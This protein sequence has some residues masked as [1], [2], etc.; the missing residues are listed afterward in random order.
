M[1]RRLPW[2]MVPVGLRPSAG[3]AAHLERQD[4]PSRP[5]GRCVFRP[6]STQ[7]HAPLATGRRRAASSADRMERHRR[8]LSGPDVP[9]PARGAQV[10]RTPTAVA[11]VCGAEEISYE[12]LNV[13]ANQLAR[14]LRT[15]G[16]GPDVVVGLCL[17][18]SIELVVGLLAILKAGGAYMPLD[19]SY[20]QE[21]LRLMVEDA[22]A[23]LLVTDAR[24]A[25]RLGATGADVV[26]LETDREVLAADRSD[27]L[28]NVATTDNLASVIF[29]SGSTG[30]PKGAMIPHRAICNHM[31]WMQTAFPLT[32]DDRV[33]QRTPYSFDAS[34]WEFYAPLIAGARLVMAPPTV[35]FDASGLVDIIAAHSVSIPATRP[36][37]AGAAARG[38]GS[39]AVREPAACL[40]WRRAALL[41]AAGAV[42]RAVR[43][44][45]PQLVR[46]GRSVHRR[47]VLDVLAR[48]RPARRSDRPPHREHPD[49]RSGSPSAAGADRRGRRAVHRRRGSGSRVHQ[50]TRPDCGTIHSE[51][52]QPGGRR[53]PL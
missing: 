41:R 49:L 50:S 32:S 4:R 53:A 27:N 52:V 29:T 42:L 24:L 40:L 12:A 48:Q 19:P 7:E 18:R 34:V 10:D 23:R 14:L 44:E 1:S 2:A 33:L 3:V 17:E 21:R 45:P 47:R 9:A 8:C 37:P 25:E 46:T 15:R 16:V 31:F 38:V 36:F 22:A 51:S 20:P 39:D 30:R 26:Y 28:D 11:V 13:R 43:R 5:P 6:E 35:R